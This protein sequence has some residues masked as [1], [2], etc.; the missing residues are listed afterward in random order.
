MNKEDSSYKSKV[1]LNSK[2]LAEVELEMSNTS[3]EIAMSGLENANAE[4]K[5]KMENAKS[6]LKTLDD[7]SIANSTGLNVKVVKELREQE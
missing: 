1:N 4:L 6:L 3:L 7:E 2:N 5:V